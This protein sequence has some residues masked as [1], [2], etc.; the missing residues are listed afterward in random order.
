MLPDM[1]EKTEKKVSEVSFQ[2]SDYDYDLPKELIAQEP[3]KDRSGSKLMVVDGL[4][5]QHKRFSDIVDF[6]EPGDVLVLNE[7]KVD[8]CRLRGHKSSG[9]KASFILS[10]RFDT[11]LYEVQI[12]CNRV[13]LGDEFV[14]PEGLTAVVAERSGMNFIVEFNKDPQPLLP[15][16]G[17]MPLPP[18]IRVPQTI[19]NR[20]LV[21]SQYQT[22]YAKT[23]GSIA[24]P[25]AGF[26]FTP[27]LLQKIESKGVGVCMIT[28]HVGY[29]TFLP[30]KESDIRDHKMHSEEFEISESS[31]SIINNRRGRLILV[32]TTTLRALESASSEM[33]I[34]RAMRGS[35][36]I[37]IYPPYDFK[38]RADMLIT[39]FHLP[40]STL[41]ML[42]SAFASKE[43]IDNAYREAIR[44]K[45]RFYSFGDAMLL[46]R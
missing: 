46:M 33:G 38:C 12:T 36:D 8:P 35:T 4:N 18:Y 11:K 1:S 14:F 31:A 19:D 39:N 43:V 34:I 6:F 21:R 45:Y 23:P 20:D 7:A 3:L 26:H 29:G 24:A 22:V 32:G 41:L 17:E 42:V 15:E 25:T 27:E 37:F 40:K 13:R 2:L 44:N 5:V 28:L 10:K 30:V 9:A 16:I